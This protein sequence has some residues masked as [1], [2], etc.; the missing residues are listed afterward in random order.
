MRKHN[1]NHTGFKGAVGDW[2]LVYSKTFEDKNLA[3]AREKEIKRWK[4]RKLI[5]KLIQQRS[6]GSEYPY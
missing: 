6:A 1:S 4:S 2:T 3:I 5:E